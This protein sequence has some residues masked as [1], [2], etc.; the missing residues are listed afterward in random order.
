MGTHHKG[1]NKEVV[2]LN[3]YIKLVRAVESLNRRL[4]P[5]LLKH[6]LS[7]S[8]FSVMEALFHLGPMNQR[9]LSSKLLRS[10]G[11]MTMVIDNLEKRKYVKRER[12]ELDRRHYIIHL[13]DA[14]KEFIKKI[15]PEQVNAIVNELG[16]LTE[17]EQCQLQK[18]CK[19]IGVREGAGKQ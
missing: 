18:M 6:G 1:T 7:E 3:T 8:Q 19:V 4:F 16:V 13:T 11:N 17:Q 15:F 2:A 10:P 5:F 12:G 9:E 14:G